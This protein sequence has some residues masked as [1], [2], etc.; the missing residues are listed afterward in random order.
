MQFE[1]EISDLK[2]LRELM[3]FDETSG[4]AHIVSNRLNKVGRR[5]ISHST[6][7][8]IA[9]KSAGGQ[10]DVS[11]KGDPA[12]TVI[13][14]DDQTLLIPE[15]LGN[16]RADTFRNILS[17]PNVALIFLV[18]GHGFSLRVSGKAKIVRDTSLSEQ[19]SVNGKTPLL[20]LVVSVEAAL[21]HCSKA[22]IRS[23]IWRSDSWPEKGLAPVLA[24]WQIEVVD[25]KRSLEEVIEAHERDAKTRL[26]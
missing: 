8:V 24:E 2:R 15:R 7:F 6:F 19:L 20:A 18:P 4:A 25:D 26:Y 23:G 3:P 5:F 17:D 1:E 9:S 14:L 16:H 22:L 13:V 10:V 12:G 21:M 11:P